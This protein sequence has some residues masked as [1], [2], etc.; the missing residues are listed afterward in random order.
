[1]GITV[2]VKHLPSAIAP[3]LHKPISAAAY[4]LYATKRMLLPG[5][6]VT[7]VP[8]GVIFD[9]P[10]DHVGLIVGRYSVSREH[11]FVLAGMIHPNSRE[12]VHVLLY[13]ARG[14]VIHQGDRVAQVVFLP[15]TAI[16]LEQT[17]I[18]E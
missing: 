14:R 5:G 11:A 17:S 3:E 4:D 8:T 18:T 2:G 12:E 15:Q 6:A 13:S 10:L 1:M 9:I 16:T 7:P